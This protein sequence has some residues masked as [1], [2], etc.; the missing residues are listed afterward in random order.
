MIMR[1]RTLRIERE[2]TQAELAVRAGVD[3]STVTKWESET[4]LP[5]TRQ[6][7]VLAKIFGCK[8]DDMFVPSQ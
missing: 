1:I 4:A 5:K 3:C 6:L 2:L 8:I 7:P